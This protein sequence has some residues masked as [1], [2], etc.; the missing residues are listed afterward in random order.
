MLNV[1]ERKVERLTNISEQ[2][3]AVEYRA[4]QQQIHEAIV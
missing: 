3:G 4:I 1:I 2:V